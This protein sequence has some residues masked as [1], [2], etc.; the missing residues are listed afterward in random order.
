MQCLPL[1]AFSFGIRSFEFCEHGM[2]C[3]WC[4]LI[5]LPW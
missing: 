3:V 2:A 1:N 5:L 4:F